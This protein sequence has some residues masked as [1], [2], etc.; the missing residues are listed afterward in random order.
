MSENP[1]DLVLTRLR[2]RLDAEEFRRWFSGTHYAADSG[3]Q[4][5]VWVHTEA[6]R[7]HIMAHFQ[8]HL[9]EALRAAGRPECDVRFV[10]TGVDDD[11]VG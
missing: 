2:R 4:I 7:R 11:D 9:D 10:V 1:W 5:T 8:R 3:D 6:I